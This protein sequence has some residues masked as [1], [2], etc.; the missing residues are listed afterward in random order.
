MLEL[1]VLVSARLPPRT[2]RNLQCG[3]DV[4][5]AVGHAFESPATSVRAADCHCYLEAP[6]VMK[7]KRPKPPVQPNFPTRRAAARWAALRR[8]AA[9]RR[10]CRSGTESPPGRRPRRR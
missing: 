10:L 9:A 3:G 4:A 8:S 5:T 7:T 2:P 6:M 1:D